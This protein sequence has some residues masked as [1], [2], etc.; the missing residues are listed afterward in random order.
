MYIVQYLCDYKCLHGSEEKLL[1]A[2]VL[3]HGQSSEEAL[4]QGAVP[5]VHFDRF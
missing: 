4:P 3:G 1:L 2:A 5:V